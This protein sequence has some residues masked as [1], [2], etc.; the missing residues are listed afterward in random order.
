MSSPEATLATLAAA[1]SSQHC[2]C[3][4]HHQLNIGVDLEMRLKMLPNHI[5]DKSSG[6]LPPQLHGCALR[7]SA[8]LGPTEYTLTHFGDVLGRGKIE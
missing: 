3:G 6:G 8:M 2:R 1:V 7:V 5:V 4:R